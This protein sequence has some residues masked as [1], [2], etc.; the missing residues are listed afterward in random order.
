MFSTLI[1]IK[2]FKALNLIFE[3]NNFSLM[4]NST[5]GEWIYWFLAIN[6]TKANKCGYCAVEI[7]IG[8]AKS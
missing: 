3:W 7:G 4:L 8:E 6:S 2:H 5:Q 1:L